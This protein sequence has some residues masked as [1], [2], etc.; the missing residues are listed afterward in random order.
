MMNEKEKSDN[1]DQKRRKIKIII[2]YGKKRERILIYVKEMIMTKNTEEKVRMMNF[3][4][5]GE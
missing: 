1:V 2:M 5:K 3:E 4:D